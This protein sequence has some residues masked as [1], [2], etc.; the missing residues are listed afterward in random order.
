MQQIT[1]LY[2]IMWL[3]KVI[4]IKFLENRYIKEYKPLNKC[5]HSSFFS[6]VRFSSTDK[7]LETHVFHQLKSLVLNVF[8]QSKDGSRWEIPISIPL[9]EFC[10]P[11]FGIF[12]LV[13]F[14]FQNKWF[15]FQ[16]IVSFLKI[17]W[18]LSI[19]LKASSKENYV[20]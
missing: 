10:I 14:I 20:F 12:Y 18:W 16:S 3:Y 9:L 11:L 2:L 6:T 17:C 13:N 19:F 15:W 5:I 1:F 4:C 7:L 8:T